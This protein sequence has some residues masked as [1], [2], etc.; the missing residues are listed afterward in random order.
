[1]LSDKDIETRAEWRSF[2][3]ETEGRIRTGSP[4]S[5][6]RHDMGLSTVIGRENADASGAPLSATMRAAIGR[7]REWDRRSSAGSRN[8]HTAFAEL[9]RI[10]AKLNLSS[11]MVEKTAYI[12]RKAQERQLARGRTIL[13]LLGACAYISCREH[14]GTLSFRDI[15]ECTGAK[16][17]ELTRMYRLLW[18]EL[19][20]K[21][22]MVDPA[23]CISMIGNKMGLSEKTKREATRMMEE[24]TMERKRDGKNPMGFAASMLYFACMTTGE[25]IV[26]KE[27][28]DAAGVTEVTIRN[29]MRDLQPMMEKYRV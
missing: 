7:W 28:A 20:L 5:V 25:R 22:P 19:D 12:Y 21:V 6:A 9:D 24:A 4:S 11:A 1:V 16:R 23:M 27:L 3:A 14:G 2:G 13:S 8:L 26:Q 17:A 18:N 15:A 10:K 29:R